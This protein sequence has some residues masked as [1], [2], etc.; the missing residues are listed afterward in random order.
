MF[1]TFEG[2]EG[3][4]KSTQIQL[5]SEQLIKRNIPHV[6]TREPGG[7]PLGEHLRSLLL[8]PTTTSQARL[9]MIWAARVQH[10]E[11]VIAPALEN[12]QWVLCDRF[13]HSTTVYQHNGEGVSM[14]II[15]SLEKCF[16]NIRPDCTFFLNLSAKDSMERIKK[17]AHN[18]YFDQKKLDFYQKIEA[19]FINLFKKDPSVIVVD[20]HESIEIIHNFIVNCVLRQ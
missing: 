3:S 8:N 14:D 1:I 5:L 10:V 13:H 11:Q 4:G 17:R 12:N 6:V 20:A 16:L 18:N 9:L 15:Q 7:T 19:G 2:G